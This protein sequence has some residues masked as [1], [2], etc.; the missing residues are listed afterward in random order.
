MDTLLGEN[1]APPN[2]LKKLGYK[3]SSHDEVI[4]NKEDPEL[5]IPKFE[6]FCRS[7][8]KTTLERMCNN[9]DAI[10]HWIYKFSRANCFKPYC[11]STACFAIELL[12]RIMLSV[13]RRPSIFEFEIIIGA[14]MIISHSQFRDDEPDSEYFE[15]IARNTDN[16]EKV[17]K[18]D[19]M[20]T[21][22][23]MFERFDLH[24]S[25]DYS[26]LGFV[27]WLGGDYE[28]TIEMKS[29]QLAL[30]DVYVS[31]EY[32]S[33]DPYTLACEILLSM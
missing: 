14:C 12:D 21:F 2:S 18:A 16:G 30:L 9:R 5:L 32:R 20:E 3:Y 13:T 29:I 7:L 19:V 31:G 1:V 15:W 11:N 23:I 17:T 24:V 8:F 33:K 6:V 26:V 22:K 4:D 25:A 28:D 27:Y 10:V